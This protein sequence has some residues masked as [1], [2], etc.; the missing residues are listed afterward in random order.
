MPGMPQKDINIEPMP[1]PIV[2]LNLPFSVFM[3]EYIIINENTVANEK[4]TMPLINLSYD[5]RDT[6]INADDIRSES[7]Y[8]IHITLD[9]LRVLGKLDSI[10][11]RT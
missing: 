11:W 2:S 1:L 7:P 5:A 3:P 9:I 4:M 6:R 8:A 10:S